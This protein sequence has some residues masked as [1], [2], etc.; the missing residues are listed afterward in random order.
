MKRMATNPGNRR[1]QR[2]SGDEKSPAVTKPPTAEEIAAWEAEKLS[3][4]ESLDS[5]FFQQVKGSLKQ[6]EKK[7]PAELGKDLAAVLQLNL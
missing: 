3:K 6:Y 2:H 7:S 5:D 1:R 4:I